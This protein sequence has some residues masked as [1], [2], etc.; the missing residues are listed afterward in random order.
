MLDTKMNAVNPVTHITYFLSS[1]ASTI[2]WGHKKVRNYSISEISP[3]GCG[4]A[5]LFLGKTF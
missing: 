5:S 3:K 4:C 1:G 2:P